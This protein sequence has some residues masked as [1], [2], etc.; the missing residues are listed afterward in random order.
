MAFKD[1]SAQRGKRGF[2][3]TFIVLNKEDRASAVVQIL[4]PTV[5]GDNAYWRHWLPMATR[6]SGKRGVGMVCPG[7]SVCPVCQR[8]KELD[9][10]DKEYLSSNKRYFV[11]VLDL[12]PRKQCPLC[13]EYTYNSNECSYCGSKLDE[14]DLAEPTV[15]LLE[16][17]KELF[18]QLNTVEET[19]T[20]PY[21]PNDPVFDHAGRDYSTYNVG[22]EAP[23]GWTR[24]PIKLV[25]NKQTGK[26]VPVGLEPNGINWEDYTDQF[27]S[28]EDAYI[29][30]LTTDEINIL[31]GGGSYGDIFSA[32]NSSDEEDEIPF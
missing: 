17:G 21:D 32:R 22:E 12:T 7:I 2:G 5:T 24:Y 26:P 23:I 31:L 13:E 6:K 11:N 18:S 16:R 10:D 1:D 8:N 25:M 20:K 27:I 19:K 28:F 14:V 29:T 30:S 4:E 15:K 3:E 9:R